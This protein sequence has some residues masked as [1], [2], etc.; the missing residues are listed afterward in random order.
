[1][2]LEDHKK[3]IEDFGFTILN[4]VF[5]YEELQSITEALELVDKNKETS[6]VSS[7]LFAV[8]QFLKEIPSVVPLVFST[9][10]NSII[11]QLFGDN[12]F[13]VK[14]IFFDKPEKSN[15]YV[16]YH[17]DLTISVDRKNE[18]LGFGPWTVKQNQ[19][20]V[21]PPLS[22]LENM[23]TIRIHL[24]DTTSE[25]GALYVIPK[26][27][28]KK[29]YRPETIDW[30]KEKEACCS[31]EKGGIMIMKPLLLHSSRRSVSGARRR[32]IHI[33]F[34]NQELPHQITWSERLNLQY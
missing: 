22:I 16:S 7:D 3:S 9:K 23:F 21:Q 30:K 5:S 14:S 11:K 10:L 8:R 24:D 25:N 20:G 33:E 28:L 12:Y 2:S 29:I 27:H 4:G 6:R 1:M 26:S 32:V 31:V 18:A 34:C 19:F 15:W 13:V 17:Q